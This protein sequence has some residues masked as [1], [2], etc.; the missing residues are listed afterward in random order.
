SAMIAAILSAAGYRAGLYHSPHLDRV[1][2]RL[3]VTDRRR[4]ARQGADR[5]EAAGLRD[6]G[7]A[8]PAHEFVDLVEQVRPNAEAVDRLPA[9]G[10][11]MS[12]TFFELTTAIALLHFAR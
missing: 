11:T 3:I 1:E 10:A 5:S 6:G 7:L 2:E 8:C 4:V 12:P 9:D